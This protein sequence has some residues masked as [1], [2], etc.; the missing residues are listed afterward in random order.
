MCR[1]PRPTLLAGFIAGSIACAL[2]GTARAT[3]VKINGQTVDLDNA[4]ED[5]LRELAGGT[6][7]VLGILA[8]EL[9]G[10]LWARRRPAVSGPG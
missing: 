7:I 3:N 8:A 9:G 5:T 4:S 2:A 6:L 1:R 10:V